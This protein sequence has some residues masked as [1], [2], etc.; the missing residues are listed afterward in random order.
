MKKIIPVAVLMISFQSLIIAQNNVGIGTT[1]PEALLHIESA[2]TDA[3]ASQLII[4]GNSNYGNATTSAIEFKSNFSSSAS[5]P[6]GRIKSFYTSNNYTDAKTIFQTIAP[7]PV[8]VDAMT[9]TNGNVGIGTTTPQAKLEVAGSIKVTTAAGSTGLDLG[10]A[11]IKVS[12]ANPAVFT[13]TATAAA[14]DIVIPNT[15]MANSATDM[16]IVTHNL[17]GTKGMAPGVFWNGTNWVIFLESGALHTIG[18]K[19]NVMVIKQ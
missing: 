2:N 3:N 14:I 11:A 1:T 9:L 18:E 13:V 6:S 16:L 12:G 15:T 4:G 19:F 7:G 5:G 10:A 17:N 8:F